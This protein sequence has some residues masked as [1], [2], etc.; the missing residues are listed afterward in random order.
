MGLLITILEPE[1]R[2]YSYIIWKTWSVERGI[3][4]YLKQKHTVL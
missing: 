4:M 3:V 2:H 1:N